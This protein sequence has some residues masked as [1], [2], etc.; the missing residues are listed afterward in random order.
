MRWCRWEDFVA[1][2]EQYTPEGGENCYCD[3][4][5]SPTWE[6]LDEAGI[7]QDVE[8]F[9]SFDLSEEGNSSVFDDLV[10]SHEWD[11][12]YCPYQNQNA[13]LTA[14]SGEYINEEY[15]PEYGFNSGDDIYANH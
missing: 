2:G 9:A 6:G 8:T 3:S 14:I 11:E 7:A 5:I 15:T 12:S 10:T 1:D 4:S 13:I